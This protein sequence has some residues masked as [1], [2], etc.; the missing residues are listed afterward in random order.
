MV[1]NLALQTRKD[2]VLVPTEAETTTSNIPTMTYDQKTFDDLMSVFNN[3]VPKFTQSMVKI[4]GTEYDDSEFMTYQGL[5]TG[6]SPVLDLFPKLSKL[7]PEK[8]RLSDEQIIRLF[9][10]DPQGRPI[11][12]GTFLEGFKREIVPQAA[13][14]PTFMGG[15]SVGQSMVAGV[16]PTTVPTAIVKFGVPLTMGTIS[17]IGGYLL[18]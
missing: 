17:A 4:L 10:F 7:P 11:S 13:S 6:T 5:K 8:R 12:S 9:A 2:E 15:F 3:D 16:P 1:Y 14:V 18:G